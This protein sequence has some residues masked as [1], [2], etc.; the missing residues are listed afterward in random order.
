MGS[1]LIL[2]G[3]KEQRR[4]HLIIN[5]ATLHTGKTINEMKIGP[6]PIMKFVVS[7]PALSNS[8]LKASVSRKPKT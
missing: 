3:M 2:L 6:I 7:K 8:W 5:R 1:R 4:I